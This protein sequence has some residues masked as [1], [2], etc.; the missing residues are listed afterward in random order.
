MPDFD[1]NLP[2]LPGLSGGSSLH[3][4]MT[5]FCKIGQLIGTLNVLG[6]LVVCAW[7]LRGIV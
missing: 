3:F 6:T 2:A 4:D 5:A 7:M 1:I